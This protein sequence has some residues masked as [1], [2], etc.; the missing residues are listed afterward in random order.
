MV[1]I[2]AMRTVWVWPTNII[3]LYGPRVVYCPMYIEINNVCSICI[4]THNY[5]SLA[6][7]S[8]QL[9]S[10]NIRIYIYIY[11]LCAC[12]VVSID[13]WSWMIWV[14][15]D[16][17]PTGETDQDRFLRSFLDPRQ[18]RIRIMGGMGKQRR[19]WSVMRCHSCHGQSMLILCMCNANNFQKYPYTDQ[20]WYTQ[21]NK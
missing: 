15:R 8:P 16:V 18:R 3:K 2:N 1:D 21:I 14:C 4:N 20:Y 12:E 7:N 11:L 19:P 5:R 9:Y 10:Y 17:H 6:N 13:T